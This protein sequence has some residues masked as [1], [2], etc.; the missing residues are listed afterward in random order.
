MTG[1]LVPFIVQSTFI[2]IP[3]AFFAATIYMCLARIIPIS[4]ADDLSIIKLQIL[5]KV[6][7][8]GDILSFGVQGSVAGFGTH[9]NLHTVM[10][11]LVVLGLAIQLVS[12]ILFGLCAI[13]FHVRV[14]RKSS[15]GQEWVGSLYMLYAV[16]VLVVVRSVFRIV[17]YA[18]GAHGYP[19]THEWTLYCFDGVP[20]ILVAVIF[21]FYY[22][23]HLV[24]KQGD[25]TIQLESQATGDSVR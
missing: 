7:V 10:T 19:L 25:D 20:M 18:F 21:L 14:R 13:I 16:S 24:P 1:S 3:P 17:E 4:G 23:S 22:P 5:T 6:F 15:V 9:P 2:L 11:A 8:H 12:F